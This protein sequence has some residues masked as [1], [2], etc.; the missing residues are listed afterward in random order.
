M[1]GLAAPDFEVLENLPSA[2]DADDQVTIDD[3]VECEAAHLDGAETLQP[4]GVGRAASLEGGLRQIVETLVVLG[5]SQAAGADRRFL[6][7]GIEK[8]VGQLGKRRHA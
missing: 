8:L 2:K 3:L 7:F 5:E 6:K 4:F 1:S